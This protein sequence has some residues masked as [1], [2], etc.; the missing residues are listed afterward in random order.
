M[1]KNQMLKR[2]CIFHKSCKAI[3]KDYKLVFNKKSQKIPQI[4]FANIEFCKDQ[5]TEG[6][7]YEIDDISYLDK[8]EGYPNHYDRKEMIIECNGEKIKAWVYIA[9]DE[10]INNYGKP[11]NE[12]IQHLLE[13]KEYL[14][15]DY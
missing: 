5:I 14:S 2:K 15:D 10:W 12:Y 13:G 3:L 8:Y 7:L 9:N 1:D 11:S 6:V 4:T